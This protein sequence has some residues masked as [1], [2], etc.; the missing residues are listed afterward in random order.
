MTT[1]AHK[2]FIQTEVEKYPAILREKKRLVLDH[3]F[4]EID[5]RK[6]GR[7]L[8]QEEKIFLN[9]DQSRHITTAMIDLVDPSFTKLFD[10]DEALRLITHNTQNKY[11]LLRSWL[12]LSGS[13]NV[14]TIGFSS[15][16][17]GLTCKWCRSLSA[18]PL[19]KKFNFPKHLEKT[20][21]CT[22]FRGE[23]QPNPRER[24]QVI[25]AGTTA[26]LHRNM[27]ATTWRVAGACR[28]L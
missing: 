4:G 11:R 5:L 12:Q 24:L 20:C 9:I 26:C 10:V 18:N 15:P 6:S 8:T 14:S 16:K 19:K 28:A 22:W 3:Y 1:S 25:D 21:N 7:V 23:L 2:K 13:S 17:D 27:E